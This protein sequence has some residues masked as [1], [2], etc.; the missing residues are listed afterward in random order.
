MIGDYTKDQLVFLILDGVQ[1]PVSGDNAVKS[2]YIAKYLSAAINWAWTKQF[3]T[4]LD[5]SEM[6][7][8]RELDDLFVGSYEVDVQWD[9]NTEVHYI[10]LPAT[11]LNL[12]KGKAIKYIGPLANQKE[13]YKPIGQSMLAAV[14]RSLGMSTKRFYLPGRDRYELINHPA[15]VKK[16][17]IKMLASVAQLKGTDLIPIPAGME[18]DVINMARDWFLGKRKLPEDT[19]VTDNRDMPTR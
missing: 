19:V 11:P 9:A 1:N 3:Y 4:E 6:E 5:S 17:M 7:G 14:S 2:L 12:P 16:L 18:I 8:L 13:G 10:V 15:S